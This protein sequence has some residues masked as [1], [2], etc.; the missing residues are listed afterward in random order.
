MTEPEDEDEIP[1][2]EID[3]GDS[4]PDTLSS[5]DGQI[6]FGLDAQTFLAH[7]LKKLGCE[8]EGGALVVGEGMSIGILHPETGKV[9]TPEEIAKKANSP[10]VRRIQ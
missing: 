7:W 1:E 9:L 4:Y 2:F 6:H 3:A 10:S 8:V 5:P